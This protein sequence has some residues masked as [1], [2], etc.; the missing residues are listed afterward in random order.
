MVYFAISSLLESLSE[1]VGY[2]LAE[3]KIAGEGWAEGVS[4]EKL[5]EW[6]RAGLEKEKELEKEFMEVTAVRYRELMGNVSR[7]SLSS[8]FLPS[9]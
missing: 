5:K 3:G 1:M 7:V 9:R 2:E 6:R 8:L 4:E